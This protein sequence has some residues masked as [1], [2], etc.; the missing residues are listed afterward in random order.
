M[1]EPRSRGSHWTSWPHSHPPPLLLREYEG[2]DPGT[3]TIFSAPRPPRIEMKTWA[4]LWLS[5][6]W[7]WLLVDRTQK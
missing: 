7:L 5:P 4:Q 1:L 2:R 6:L 3:R